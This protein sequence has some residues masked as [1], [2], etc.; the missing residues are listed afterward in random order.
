MLKFTQ[1]PY[2]NLIIG[3]INFVRI[4]SFVNFKYYFCKDT[5][6]RN[7]ICMTCAIYMRVKQNNLKR[8]AKYAKTAKSR[9]R[10]MTPTQIY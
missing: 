7:Y 10:F 4:T 8:E 1:Q 3:T 2:Q 5:R 9:V 6:V